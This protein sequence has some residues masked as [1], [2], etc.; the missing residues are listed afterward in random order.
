MVFDPREEDP[1]MLPVDRHVVPV[2]GRYE[3]LDGELAYVPP[4]ERA[5]GQAHNTLGALVQGHLRFAFLVGS[6]I[7]TRTSEDNDFAP[8]VSI[9]PREPHPKT[10]GRQLDELAFEIVNKQAMS[11]AAYKA[12]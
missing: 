6:D 5:H 10:G 1:H 4:A 9:Y 11:V 3:L 8:D 7:L 2:E 12:N